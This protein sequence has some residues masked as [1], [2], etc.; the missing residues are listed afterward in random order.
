MSTENKVLTELNSSEKLRAAGRHHEWEQYFLAKE[1]SDDDI[2][3]SPT[4]VDLHL[5]VRYITFLR[6]RVREIP[7]NVRVLHLASFVGGMFIGG[8]LTLGTLYLVVTHF[9]PS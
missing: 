8:I 1:L 7:E 2:T 6:N 4:L 3:N 9:L 5:F